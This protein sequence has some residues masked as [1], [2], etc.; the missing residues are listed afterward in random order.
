LV[1]TLA[2]AV[3]TLRSLR[4]LTDQT[5]RSLPALI[6]K[7]DA[8]VSAVSTEV[9]RVSVVID[10]IEGIAARLGH[11]VTAVHEAVNVPASVVAAAGERLR[12]VLRRATRSRATAGEER[13]E[14]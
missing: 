13:A 9:S 4:E 5:A 8:A 12:H 14:H 2:E 11:T 3:K 7:A 6:E 10:E 1:V